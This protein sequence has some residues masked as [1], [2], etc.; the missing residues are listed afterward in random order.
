VWTNLCRV[1][2]NYEAHI[3]PLWDL[4]R[5]AADNVTDITCTLCHNNRDAANM[6]QVPAG[7]LELTDGPSVVQP[8]HF[9][10][11]R[12]LLFT[13]NEQELSMGALQ[14]RLIEIGIDPVT[15]DPILVPI[16]VGQSMRTAGSRNSSFFNRFRAG[17]SHQD[18]LT[19]HELRLISE[20]L[21]I[22][23]QYFNNPFDAPLD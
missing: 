21:D 9:L 15:G 19:S 10:S 22:G 5:L 3:H 13:D 12:E 4:P 6:L 18:Y 14:D 23:G 1:V 7:Q 8:D 20:W 11:Y 2:I 16:S 17:E